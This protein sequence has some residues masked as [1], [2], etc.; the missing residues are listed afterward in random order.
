MVGCQYPHL[1]Q[2]AAGRVSQRTA[3]LVSCPQA[4]VGISNSVR[5]CCPCTR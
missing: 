1:S 3:M 4:Q 5:V 2:S